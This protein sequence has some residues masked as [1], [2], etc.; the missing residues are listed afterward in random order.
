[1]SGKGPQ[2]YIRVGRSCDSWFIVHAYELVVIQRRLG[3]RQL[4]SNR[5][6]DSEPDSVIKGPNNYKIGLFY[7]WEVWSLV[8]LSGLGTSG[9]DLQ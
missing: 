5:K 9:E 7:C 8:P 2:W 1:M 4:N 3:V 6:P